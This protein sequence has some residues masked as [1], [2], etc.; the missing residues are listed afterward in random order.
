MS[1]VYIGFIAKAKFHDLER[2]RSSN[3][4]RCRSVIE[5]SHRWMRGSVIFS[6]PK[7][8]CQRK[9]STHTMK[10]REIETSFIS[11]YFFLRKSSI[12]L[13]RFEVS[14]PSVSLSCREG[15]LEC[16]GSVSGTFQRKIRIL[17]PKIR[18]ER[19]SAGSCRISWDFWNSTRNATKGSTSVF[20]WP[21]IASIID[22]PLSE[23]DGESDL[24]RAKS[25]N[26]RSVT[27][28][29]SQVTFRSLLSKWEKLWNDIRG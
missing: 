10:G 20:F 19:A 23:F 21:P 27:E 29:V 16:D 6:K 5:L 14:H 28:R 7:L 12:G 26:C 2:R 8:D 1:H 15:A 4:A 9:G 11:K 13:I 3:S 24:E 22:H 17:R 18:L 25:Q